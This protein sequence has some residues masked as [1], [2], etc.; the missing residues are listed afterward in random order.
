MSLCYILD[1]GHLRGHASKYVGWSGCM[2]ASRGC[3]DIQISWYVNCA[4][5][6]CYQIEAGAPRRGVVRLFVWSLEKV[7]S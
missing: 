6:A 4:V 3:E 1:A 5:R 2:M 7:L